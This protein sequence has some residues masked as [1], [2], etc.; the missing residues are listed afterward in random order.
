MEELEACSECGGTGFPEI[1]YE[2]AQDWIE[3]G[4][5]HDEPYCNHCGGTG[6]EPD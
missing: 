5:P 6:V 1:T 4:C 2:P 3:R